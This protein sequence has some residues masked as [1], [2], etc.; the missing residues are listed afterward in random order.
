MATF[1]SSTAGSETTRVVWSRSAAKPEVDMI[2]GRRIDD[3]WLKGDV[4]IV[5]IRMVGPLQEA[6]ADLVDCARQNGDKVNLPT[7]ALRLLLQSRMQGVVS[8]NPKIGSDTKAAIEMY[9]GGESDEKLVVQIVGILMEWSRQSLGQWAHARQ[10]DALAARVKAAAVVDNIEVSR[11]K[12]PLV[13]PQCGPDYALIARQLADRL[14]GEELFEGMKGCELVLYAGAG[15]NKIDL[16]TAPRRNGRSNCLFSMVATITVSSAPYVSGLYMTI[17]PSKRVWTEKMP[18]GGNTGDTAT[19]YVMMPNAP[20]IPCQVL[21]TKKDGVKTWE[22]A[23]EYQSLCY[24]SLRDPSMEALPRN[25]RGALAAPYPEKGWWCGLPQT[26][27]LFRRVDART[28]FER[29]EVDLLRTAEPFL[30]GMI[31]PTPISHRKC[32]LSL[33]R[34]S[35]SVMVQTGDIGPAGGLDVV[36]DREDSVDNGAAGDVVEE[37]DKIAAFR[38]QNTIVLKD[39]HTAKPHLWI[40]AKNPDERRCMEEIAKLLFGDAITVSGEPLPEGVHGLRADLPGD[41]SMKARQRFAL[42]VKTWADS[43]IVNA[44]KMRSGPQ[45]VLI[46]ADKEIN[47]RAE[48]SVNRRAA[49]H[50]ICKYTGAGVHH[51]LPP[52]RLKNGLRNSK[53]YQAFIHRVQSAMMD[54]LLAHSGYVIGAGDFIRKELGDAMPTKAIYGI[55]AL[56]A[57]AQQFTAEIPVTMIV[58]TRLI[59]DTDITEI[60]FVYRDAT[61][62]KISGWK[63]LAEGLIWLGSQRDHSGDENWLRDEFAIRTKEMLSAAYAEDPYA[64]VLADSGNLYGIWKEI[65]DRSL[66]AQRDPFL[67]NVNLATTFPTMTF[68]RLRYGRLASMILRFQQETVFEGYREGPSLI[69]TGELYS[70][71]YPTTGRRLIELIDPKAPRNKSKGHFV[72]VLGYRS[73]SQGKRGLSCYRKTIRMTPDTSQRTVFVKMAYD[74]KEDDSAIPATMDITVMHAPQE[75]STEA[76]ATIVMGLRYGYPHYSDW[77]L[78][79][80]PLFFNRKIDD[81][82]IKYPLSEGEDLEA[83]EGAAESIEDSAGTEEVDAGKLPAFREVATKIAKENPL[84]EEELVEDQRDASEPATAPMVQLELLTEPG[85]EPPS[86]EDGEAF[87]GIDESTLPELILRARKEKYIYLYPPVDATRRE[88]WRGI[89]RHPKMKVRVELPYFVEL[90]GFY[91]TYSSDKKNAIVKTW[92]QMVKFGYVPPNMQRPPNEEFL[93]WLAKRLLQPQGAFGVFP[94]ILFGRDLIIPQLHNAV[95]AFNATAKE[96]ISLRDEDGSPRID[97]S[98]LVKKATDEKNDV[99][100]GWLIFAAAQTPSFYCAHSIIRSLTALTGPR[101]EAALHYYLDCVEVVQQAM[102]QYQANGTQGFKPIYRPRSFQPPVVEPEEVAPSAAAPTPKPIASALAMAFPEV[103]PDVLPEVPPNA[104]AGVRENHSSPTLHSS[105]GD[106]VMTIKQQLHALIDGLTPGAD[107]FDRTTQSMVDALSELRALHEESL[108]RLSEAN[109]TPTRFAALLTA[110]DAI[111]SEVASFNEDEMFSGLRY[112][113][114]SEDVLDAAEQDLESIQLQ[115]KMARDAKLKLMNAQSAQSATVKVSMMEQLRRATEQANLL[116]ELVEAVNTLKQLFESSCCFEFVGAPTPPPEG[117]PLKETEEVKEEDSSVTETVDVASEPSVPVSTPTAPDRTA[118]SA[119]ATMT[120]PA[121]ATVVAPSAPVTPAPQEAVAPA[122]LPAKTRVAPSEPAKPVKA[123]AVM[124]AVAESAPALPSPVETPEVTASLDSDQDNLLDIFRPDAEE[125]EK[126]CTLLNALFAKRYYGLAA[127]HADAM[128]LAF[129]DKALSNHCTILVAMANAMEAI[130]CQFAINPKLDGPLRDLLQSTEELGQNEY[131]Q[132]AYWALGVLAAGFVPALMSSIDVQN[133]AR[134]TVIDAIS[135][136]VTGFTRLNALVQH[137]GKMDMQAVMLTREKFSA[138]NL[139]SE[140]AAKAELKRMQERAANWKSDAQMITAWTHGG[141][142]RMHDEIYSNRH[143]IGTCL[144][145]I[146]RGDLKHLQQS[147]DRAKR[148]FAKPAQTVT[149]TFRQIGE[150]SKPD[151]RQAVQSAENI[152]TTLRFIESYIELA[153]GSGTQPTAELQRNDREYLITLHTLITAAK[154]ELRE[155]APT[156]TIDKIYVLGARAIL[157]AVLRLYDDARGE[158]CIPEA[159]QRLMLQVLMDRDFQPSIRENKES[160]IAAPYSPGDV[161]IEVESL[162]KSLRSVG[163]PPSSAA[164]NQVLWDALKNHRHNRRYLPAFAIEKFLPKGQFKL[165]EPLFSYYQR[166]KADLGRELQDAR[167]RVTHAMALSAVEQKEANEL[168][169]VIEHISASAKPEESIGHPNGTSLAYPDFPHARLVLRTKVLDVLEAKLAE[170]SKKLHNDLNEYVEKHGTEVEYDV[171]RVRDILK[172]TNAASLRTAHDAFTILRKDKKLPSNISRG[173]V[174][175]VEYEEFIQDLPTTI[176]SHNRLLETVLNLLRDGDKATLPEKLAHLSDEDRKEA[177]DFIALWIDLCVET[178]RIVA[179]EKAGKF[180][181]LIGIPAP[182]YTPENGRNKNLSRFIFPEG[183]LSPLMTSECFLPPELGTQAK[184]IMG[185]VVSGN[186]NEVEL[187][188]YIQDVTNVPTFLLA[189]GRLTLAKRA[190]MTGHQMVMLIDDN[191]VA[192]MAL[193]RDERARRMMEI[194]TL[195]FRAHPYSAD[196]SS[197]PRE[198]FFGRQNELAELRTMQSLGVLYGGRR[199]G[200]SSL[201]KQIE[202]EVNNVKGDVAIYMQMDGFIGESHVL[203]AWREVAKALASAGV[204]ESL[205]GSLRSWGEIRDWVQDQLTKPGKAHHSCY[206]LFDEA[207]T[208]MGYELALRSNEPGF[209]RTFQQMVEAIQSKFHIRY[210]I[211]GLHNLAR[212]TAESNSALAK[213]KTIA[214]EP[215]NSSD[216]ILRGIQLVTK[217]LGA[218]G[219]FF[220]QGREDLPLQIMSVCN[221]YPAFIQVYCKKLLAHM[222][223]KRRVDEAYTYIDVADLDAV[224]KDNELLSELQTKFSY[225]LHLDK[226]YQGIALILADVYYAEIENGKNEGLT[227]AEIQEYTQIALDAH[228]RGMS[229]GAYEGLVDEMRKLSVLELNGSRYRL[230][231]P[232]IAMLIGDRESISHKLNVLA[233]DPPETTRNRGDRRHFMEVPGSKNRMLF[234]M[235]IAWTHARMDQVDGGLVIIAGNNQSGIGGIA[236]ASQDWPL[237]HSDAYR[238][239]TLSHTAAL[240]QI[241]KYR[242]TKTSKGARYDKLMLASTPGAWKASDIPSFASVSAKAAPSI[243]LALL[244]HPDRMFELS[245]AIKAQTLPQ[246]NKRLQWEVS[247]ITPWSRDALMFHIEENIPVAESKEACDAI[248][249]ASCGFGKLIEGWCTESLTVEF[250]CGLYELAMRTVAPDLDTFYAHVGWPHAMPVAMRKNMEQFMAFAHGLLRNSLEVDEYLKEFDLVQVDLQF[251]TWMGLM[252]SADD[253]TW[254]VPE[255][256]RRLIN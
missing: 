77:T 247:P 161:L 210:V 59:I 234:P 141:F 188:S 36:E 119:A 34:A 27:R 203:Y 105:D 26:T 202:S 81:Y 7:S 226:R 145:W 31:D 49:I 20:H 136:P 171:N 164:I 122:G 251:L 214:L 178:S 205:P 255:L 166:E 83:P 56:R 98:V 82:I 222:Y 71:A 182:S 132:G 6:L 114:V 256:Y 88:V 127:V 66:T 163:D 228:F 72:G 80:A 137:L 149:E 121:P 233:S 10:L 94:R 249:K 87:A 85:N 185:M 194:C 2:V 196:G 197:V 138:Q 1:L 44:I 62:T 199:L 250:A 68:A 242:R 246:P 116:N 131:S 150:R 148:L 41:A 42:R 63:P 253:G 47:R 5:C 190:R 24:E 135:H 193:H 18:D 39:I 175:P 139:G 144:Q 89:M 167:Q 239:M 96:R 183:A 107:D 19:A 102:D 61:G 252:Q 170:T 204:I 192:Y 160:G 104:P 106:R 174:A 65:S 165:D 21:M 13:S 230:R 28:P 241:D 248:L 200:K 78:L 220:A 206:I 176:H 22:F 229:Q 128:S 156:A 115:L 216:D 221:F 237:N 215:F 140:M 117:E 16:M 110:A 130:D 38:E 33:N 158:L 123:P 223:N 146:S 54:V 231:N 14:V 93:D 113:T 46:C 133:D 32:R 187:S 111:A 64:V 95:E 173:K 45:Y 240:Q 43:A 179:A 232:S 73:T 243:R 186:Q 70:D 90:Q 3:E 238:A 184:L 4:D 11:S 92:K 126:Q 15:S 208:L 162:V 69:P 143:P 120:Q 209:I 224:E 172:T 212:M 52:E 217:P 103:K 207:D 51:V 25:L 30:S 50:A 84:S 254:M 129:Q 12:K 236:V 76:I 48:D 191:L 218:L 177:A 201:L 108:R 97:M 57:R 91:G 181:S 153:H 58:Y 189:R 152:T 168:L 40:L 142:M 134:W 118:S 157:Q 159:E 9:D 180:F 55:Q 125:V 86:D 101:S 100:L 8:V 60:K 29:D 198:M 53:T 235:P 75:T 169:R 213:A 35:K 219:F 74:V 67:G 147:L 195:T 245:E 109:R 154:D 99:L 124:T 151:G 225:T 227:V 79:P 244:A 23:D 211:T 112:I 37:R 17:A 155:L